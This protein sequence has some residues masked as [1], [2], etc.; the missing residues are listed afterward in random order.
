MVGLLFVEQ[1]YG[2][3]R[4]LSMRV[5]FGFDVYPL[6]ENRPLIIGGVQ[7]PFEKGLQVNSDADVMAHAVADALLGAAGSGDIGEHFPDN[8]DPYKNFDSMIFLKEIEKKVN[9]EKY[10]ISNVDITLVLQKPKISQY[11]SQMEDNIAK[12]LYLKPNQV[13]VKVTTSEGHGFVGKEEGI[14][15]YAVALLLPK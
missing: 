12:N 7:I 15:C 14:A 9:F 1:K 5:G 3:I 11:K 13:N 4:E 2:E 8:D 6:V 10:K